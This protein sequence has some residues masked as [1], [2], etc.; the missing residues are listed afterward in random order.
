MIGQLWN[1]VKIGFKKKIFIFSIVFFGL[2]FYNI[3]PDPLIKTLFFIVTLPFIPIMAFIAALDSVN[4]LKETILMQFKE[5]MEIPVPNEIQELADVMGVKI[6]KV[7][8]LKNMLNA[9][10]YPNGTVIIGDKIISDLDK[11][12]LRAV[13]AHEFSHIKRRHHLWKVLAF[14][15]F[16]LVG[17]IAFLNV[18]GVFQ[19]YAV[20]AFLSIAIIPINWH[21]E[22]EADNDAKKFVGASPLA[23]ALEKISKGK[24]P[25]EGSETH[26]P[27]NQRI[28]LLHR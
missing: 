23:S 24:N 15:G 13:Y 1:F 7:K 9:G 27:T 28:E 18:P 20:L 8:M 17:Y 11:N 12:Q 14:I 26:P 21:F 6:K 3:V 19:G 10:A 16:L 2:S 4:N 25:D 22:I 5:R